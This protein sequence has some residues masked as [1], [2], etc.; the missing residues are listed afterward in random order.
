MNIGKK[1]INEAKNADRMLY[2]TRIR[3]TYNICK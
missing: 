3:V 1:D 2:D